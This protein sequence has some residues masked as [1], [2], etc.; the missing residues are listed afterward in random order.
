M[1]TWVILK[2]KCDHVTSL[3]KVPQW[4]LMTFQ[5]LLYCWIE[6][7]SAYPVP[8]NVTSSWATVL[9]LCLTFAIHNIMFHSSRAWQIH[10]TLCLSSILIQPCERVFLHYDP[11]EMSSLPYTSTVSCFI[12]FSHGKLKPVSSGICCTTW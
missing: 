7:W 8:F 10:I 1:F 12:F 3:L 11:D 6:P 5:W 4:F 9:T 2:R